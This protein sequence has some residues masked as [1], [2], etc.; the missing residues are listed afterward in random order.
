MVFGVTNSVLCI[1][2]K[3]GMRLLFRVL[4][5]EEH[6]QVKVLG[7]EDIILPTRLSLKLMFLIFQEYGV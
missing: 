6:A 4:K 2:L 7:V 3:F 5:N 1:F